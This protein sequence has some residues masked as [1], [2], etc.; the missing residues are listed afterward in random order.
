MFYV[1][2]DVVLPGA[3]GKTSEGELFEAGYDDSGEPL[4]EE[5]IQWHISQH[6]GLR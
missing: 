5:C 4:R 2:A 6:I 3:I 1:L